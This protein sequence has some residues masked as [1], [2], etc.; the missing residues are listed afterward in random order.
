MLQ[1]LIIA[2][3]IL[4]APSVYASSCYCA[5]SYGGAN[6]IGDCPPYAC[7]NTKCWQTERP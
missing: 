6:P 3:I 4:T 7:V 1:K 2:A 5:C